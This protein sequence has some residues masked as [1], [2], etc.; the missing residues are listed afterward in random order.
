MPLVL[1]EFLVVGNIFVWEP[2]YFSVR[3]LIDIHL[4]GEN[5]SY[6]RRKI[7]KYGNHYALVPIILVNRSLVAF[8]SSHVFVPVLS[9]ILELL[10]LFHNSDRF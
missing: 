7:N 8:S 1:F 2:Y 6:Q 4:H 3:S 5:I 10:N 9:R